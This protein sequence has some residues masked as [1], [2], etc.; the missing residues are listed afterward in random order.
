MLPAQTDTTAKVSFKKSKLYRGKIIESTETSLPSETLCD[1]QNFTQ[2][3]VSN[4]TPNLL[5]SSISVTPTERRLSVNTIKSSVSR[6]F[7]NVKKELKVNTLHL[8][9]EV[10]G[11]TVKL[12]Y[13]DSLKL[14][15]S[16]LFESRLELWEYVEDSIWLLLKNIVIT[17]S[18]A[19]D[20]FLTMSWALNEL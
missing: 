5:S 9:R 10:L 13:R 8:N 12:F 19:L 20:D 6:R 14:V 1:D 3:D 15:Y 11:N 18:I 2:L 16:K 4:E 17:S 7:S